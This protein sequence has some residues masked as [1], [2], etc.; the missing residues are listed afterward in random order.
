LIIKTVHTDR[1]KYEPLTLDH[2]SL[3]CEALTDPIV[4][5]HILG[6]FP[7]SL[8]ALTKRFEATLRGPK[9]EWKNETWINYAIVEKATGIGVGR[10]E[11]TIIQPD[12]VTDST[13]TRA[14]VAYLLGPKFWGKG[15]GFEALGWLIDQLHKMN[16]PVIYATVHPNNSPSIRLLKRFEF[17]ELT[18]GWPMLTSYDEGDRVFC[19]NLTVQ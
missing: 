15:Y 14:E 3:L 1:L 4:Y 7:N 19:K 8:D 17:T 10:L 9:P 13:F 18:Q 12:H 16:I 5:A 6:D 2:A 11:A